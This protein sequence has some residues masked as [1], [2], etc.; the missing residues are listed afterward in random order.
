[1]AR[2]NPLNKLPIYT[3]L[4]MYS[5]NWFWSDLVAACMVLVILIPQSM[6]YSLIAG[7]PPI[8]GLY[9]AFA[10]L[11]LY[12]I[13]GTSRQMS[14]GP[15][16]LSG[17]IILG[18]VSTVAEPFTP[19]Y[20]E[21]TIMLTVFVGILQ[22]TM[23]ILRLGFI[24]ALLSRPVITGFI[25]AAALIIIVSQLKY[26]TGVTLE[27]QQYIYQT[28]YT[29]ISKS[30]TYQVIPILLG[31]M[32]IVSMY[33]GKKY[34]PKIPIALILVI[35][36]SMA[37]YYFNWVDMEVRVIGHI[38]KGM[39]TFKLPTFDMDVLIKLIPTLLG[40]ASISIVDSTG[41]AKSIEQQQN[42]YKLIPNMELIALGISKIGGAF[43]QAFSGSASFARSAINF[44]AG[45]KTAM[46]SIYLGVLLAIVLN[47]FTHLFY[48]IPYAIL[49]AIII[50]SVSKMF[51]I[52]EFHKLYKEDKLD[53]IAAIGTFFC[54]LFLGIE[55]G[56]ISGISLSLIFF[57][58]KKVRLHRQIK[59]TGPL[60][61][62]HYL[63]T[64]KLHTTLNEIENKATFDLFMKQK[65]IVILD[66][67][68]QL[69]IDLYRHK[70]NY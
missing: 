24:A 70:K 1:M 69:I 33:V 48:F 63:N 13:F 32:T 20:I 66:S 42:R 47:F 19:A 40:L 3:D 30:S 65:N 11:I 8:Y 54:T 10:P 7:L 6:A 51:K 56:V 39:P 34:I 9:A 15:V 31:L 4:R 29:L 58:L 53:F 25:S 23:G 37:C 46:S 60:T 59:S 49:G 17:L 36:G 68:A 50:F 38:K 27:T 22:L 12:A 52:R 5:S 35:L 67:T 21:Y 43:F 41:I 16:A 28:V 64:Q 61:V 26:I 18:G 57:L 55:I 14:V 45:A 44:N 2:S 62:F